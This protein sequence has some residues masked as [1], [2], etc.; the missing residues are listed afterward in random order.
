MEQTLNKYEMKRKT[1]VIITG[2]Q[3]S[4]F[5]HTLSL[6]HARIQAHK[7]HIKDFKVSKQSQRIVSDQR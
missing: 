6:S 2:K 4:T 3:T 1:E 5:T 7:S